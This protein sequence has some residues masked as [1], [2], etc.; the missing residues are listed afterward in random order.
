MALEYTDISSKYTRA[1]DLLDRERLA[2]A[3]VAR[4]KRKHGKRHGVGKAQ[5]VITERKRKDRAA[6]FKKRDAMLKAFHALVREYWKGDRKE[7]P[8]VPKV[9]AMPKYENPCWNYK[10]K[11]NARR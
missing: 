8:E 2:E 9:P 6:Y 3:K 11:R 5:A 4:T 10:K 7:F 1:R